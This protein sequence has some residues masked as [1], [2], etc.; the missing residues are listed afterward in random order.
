MD[1]FAIKKGGNV[2]IGTTNAARKFMVHGGSARMGIKNSTEG[3]VLGLLSDDAGYFQLNSA[4]G[5]TQIQLRADAGDSYITGQLGIGTKSPSSTLTVFGDVA[6]TAKIQIEGEG[7]ADPYINF[8]VN[9]T[10][11]WAMGADDDA[12]DSFKISQHSALGTNDRLT[13]L[14]AGNVG[15]GTANPGE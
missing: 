12:S 7:G 1:A 14:S 13:I 11:H 3:V 8:L 6:G 10:T 5:T 9:N 4:D 2:G 15:I